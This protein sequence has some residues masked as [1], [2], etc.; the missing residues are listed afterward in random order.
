MLD[1]DTKEAWGVDNSHVDNWDPAC[2][3]ARHK[4]A[5]PGIDENNL[6][7]TFSPEKIWRIIE[8]VIALINIDAY[9]YIAWL[10]VSVDGKRKPGT[11][12]FLRS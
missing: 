7:L 2:T 1:G 12:K 8:I 4:N 3:R 6:P 5:H 9:S 11:I 10:F